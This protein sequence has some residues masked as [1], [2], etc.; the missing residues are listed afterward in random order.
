MSMQHET[1]EEEIA[2]ILD[3]HSKFSN[4]G[5]PI[6]N[7]VSAA[8][9]RRWQ[10]RRESGTRPADIAAETGHHKWTAYVHSSDNCSHEHGGEQ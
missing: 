2:A 6:E 3:R 9:C 1:T 8:E 7:R 4:E 10:E 5:G